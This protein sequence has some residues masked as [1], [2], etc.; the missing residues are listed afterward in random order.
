V[1]PYLSADSAP[2]GSPQTYV[3]VPTP[4]AYMSQYFTHGRGSLRYLLFINGS[5]FVS[6]VVRISYFPGTAPASIEAYG[7]DHVS[8]LVEVKGPT[9]VKFTIP[10]Q[11]A[12]PWLPLQEDGGAS[13]IPMAPF[14]PNNTGTFPVKVLS[15]G[16]IVVSV[17][18]PLVVTSTT[19]NPIYYMSLFQAAGKDWQFSRFCGRHAMTGVPVF[20]MGSAS[21]PTKVKLQASL[22]ALA[23]EDFPGLKEGLV[24][25]RDNGMVFSDR[26][27]AFLDLLHRYSDAE[28]TITGSVMMNTDVWWHGTTSSV[29]NTGNAGDF[30]SELCIL[31]KFHR[32]SIRYCFVPAT[33]EQAAIHSFQTRPV[34]ITSVRDQAA[35]GRLF[36]NPTPGKMRGYDCVEVPWISVSPYRF[37]YQQLNPTAPSEPYK[38]LCEFGADV[39]E[40]W[41]SAGDDFG[42]SGPLPCPALRM[43]TDAPGADGPQKIRLQLAS[44]ISSREQQL[45][46]KLEA[47]ERVIAMHVSKP[48]A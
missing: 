19:V 20:E 15:W 9:W 16:N 12:Y 27:R 45:L 37:T 11:S 32:G 40:V 14:G 24:L 38:L 35:P 23:L 3:V 42:L 4:L 1:S 13:K 36:N 34:A 47:A 39:A 31:F 18:E 33:T 30:F 21:D 7:G 2:S 8:R 6:G 46:Q 10:Y 28:T 5:Q 25:E 43:R 17:V 41:R 26:P 44:S 48:N 29:W 22:A